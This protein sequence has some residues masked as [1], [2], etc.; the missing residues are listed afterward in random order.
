[1][2]VEEALEVEVGEVL[3]LRDGEEL[4]ERS[5]GLDVVLVLEVLFLDV[6][7]Y[8]LGDLRAAHQGALGLAEEGA[9][10]IRDL[11]GALEDGGSTLDGLTILRGGGRTALTLAGILD[12]TV[13]ALLELLDLRHHGGNRLTE[14][15]EAGH[16][17]LDVLVKSGRGSSGRG[18]SSLYRGRGYNNR[19]RGGHGGGLLGRL[20]LGLSGNNRGGGR[21][22]NGLR[23][24]GRILLG[25]TLDS[26]GGGGGSAH[27]TR[28]GGRIRGHFTRYV[29]VIRDLSRQF[30][31]AEDPKFF[32]GGAGLDGRRSFK[33]PPPTFNGCREI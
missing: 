15:G 21:S 14:S 7:V 8:A 4:T 13:N 22:G 29:H 11:D 16:D 26:L 30:W 31:V 2:A 9:E 25:N 6:V 10:L 12:L 19:G 1:M 17:G 33:L 24:G 3:S 27:Y 5:I 20:G 23:D 32:S 28:G 18:G